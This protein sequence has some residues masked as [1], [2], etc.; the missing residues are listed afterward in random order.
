M[1]ELFLL[2]MVLCCGCY[3]QVRPLNQKTDTLSLNHYFGI[4]HR[5]TRSYQTKTID[6]TIDKYLKVF[7][8]ALDYST[9]PLHLTDQS[10][11][12]IR[13]TSNSTSNSYFRNLGFGKDGSN[14]LSGTRFNKSYSQYSKRYD[15]LYRKD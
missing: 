15:Y 4:F 5:Q 2:C 3:A 1:K 13:L 9:T 14:N 12:K 7:N 10:I 6:A 11:I 8:Q